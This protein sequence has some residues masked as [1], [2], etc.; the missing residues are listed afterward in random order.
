MLL[1]GWVLFWALLTRLMPG[2]QF[3]HDLMAGTR[4]I[5]QEPPKDAESK[6]KWWQL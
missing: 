4:L 1:L 3:A 5:S 6:R 2:R